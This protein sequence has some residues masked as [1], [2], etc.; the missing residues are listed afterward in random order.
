MNHG[1][2][3]SHSDLDL[4]TPLVIIIPLRPLSNVPFAAPPGLKMV[5]FWRR[6]FNPRSRVKLRR[7]GVVQ[8]TGMKATLGKGYLLRES[9]TPR[10]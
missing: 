2:D 1:H 9:L 3:S 5:D 7:G 10:T 8:G 4:S 6:C